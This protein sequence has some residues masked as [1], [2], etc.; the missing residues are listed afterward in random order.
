MRCISRKSGK[1]NIDITQGALTLLS[2]QF[3]QNGSRYVAIV[4]CFEQLLAT[5]VMR[6]RRNS[7]QE[8]CWAALTLNPKVKIERVVTFRSPFQNLLP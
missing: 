6:D 5:V 7:T 4:R 1:A 2:L 8:G 3:L